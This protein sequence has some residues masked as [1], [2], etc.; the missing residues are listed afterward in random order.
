MRLFWSI[1][2]G[3][4]FLLGLQPAF[5]DI[6]TAEDEAAFHVL[7]VPYYK[8]TFEIQREM[9]ANLQDDG[10]L[11]RLSREQYQFSKAF[12]GDT[13]SLLTKW[14]ANGKALGAYK[15]LFIG[16]ADSQAQDAIHLSDFC[17]KADTKDVPDDVGNIE[18][19]AQ[20]VYLKT[21]FTELEFE[22]ARAEQVGDEL[23]AC[24]DLKA[25]DV[26]VDELA[27]ESETLSE[28]S[29]GNRQSEFQLEGRELRA[30]Q[31]RYVSD[32]A[33]CL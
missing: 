24:A 8:R 33:K 32:F 19:L 29:D 23:L 2:L 22:W 11:C 26:I 20:N 14:L 6:V 13:Y 1:A 17:A 12:K 25:L 31:S 30:K 16:I 18:M 7:S 3:V 4:A 27:F 9:L 28:Y 15:K 5:A 10:R 21:F